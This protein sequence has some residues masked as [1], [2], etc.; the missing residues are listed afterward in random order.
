MTEPTGRQLGLI[1]FLMS[2][3]WLNSSAFVRMIFLLGNSLSELG[4]ADMDRLDCFILVRC[5]RAM[6]GLL[7]CGVSMF[8]DENF[9]P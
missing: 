8:T 7:M 3:S 9:S 1:S 4:L 5:L 2:L 6:A